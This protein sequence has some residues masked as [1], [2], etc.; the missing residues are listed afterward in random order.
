MKAK[1]PIC[2][3]DLDV[4]RGQEDIKLLT[5]VV[6]IM[7]KATA[8]HYEKIEAT[9]KNEWDGYESDYEHMMAYI[10]RIEKL[11]L[12]DLRI[13][14]KDGYGKDLMAGLLEGKDYYTSEAMKE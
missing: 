9:L 10:I 13:R 3:N 11:L 7:L 8:K 12:E 6:E 2:H 1:C 5:D 14:Y 4:D